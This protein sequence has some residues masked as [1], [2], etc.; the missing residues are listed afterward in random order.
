[1][2][3]ENRTPEKSAPSQKPRQGMHKDE[4]AHKG[5]EAQHE[6]GGQPS[7]TP[8]KQAEE[9]R[10]GEHRSPSQHR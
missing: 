2:T 5:H 6:R 9:H 7:G 4:P 3:N 8:G 1:M 10:K